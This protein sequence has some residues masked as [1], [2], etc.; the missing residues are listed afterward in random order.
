MLR[1]ELPWNRLQAV[2]VDDS[3][4]SPLV[5]EA[6]EHP[7]DE[8]AQSALEDVDLLWFATQEVEDLL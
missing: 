3:A 6:L 2:H 5:T 7:D 1:A 4:T 8:S